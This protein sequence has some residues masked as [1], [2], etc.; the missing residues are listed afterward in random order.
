MTIIVDL[1]MERDLFSKVYYMVNKG[2]V[3]NETRK[4]LNLIE[5]FIQA[6]DYQL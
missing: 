4:C 1:S 3:K 6:L 2:F 5:D